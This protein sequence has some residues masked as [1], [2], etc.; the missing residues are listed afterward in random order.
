MSNIAC[1][2]EA[3]TKIVKKIYLWANLNERESE[4]FNPHIKI[5]F[6]HIVWWANNFF[7]WE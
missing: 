6:H 1:S 4:F 7:H 2:Q 3:V 5:N